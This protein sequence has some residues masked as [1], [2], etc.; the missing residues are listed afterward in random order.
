MEYTDKILNVAQ[1]IVDGMKCLKKNENATGAS[2][3]GAPTDPPL[4]TLDARDTAEEIQ[5]RV[6]AKQEILKKMHN[7]N[8]R[9]A[10]VSARAASR[11]AS[12]AAA[13]RAHSNFLNTLPAPPAPG[14]GAPPPPPPPAPGAGAPPPPPPPAPGAAA[15]GAAAPAPSSLLAPPGARALQPAL[16]RAKPPA[17]ARAHSNFLNTLPAPPAPGAGAPPPPPPAAAKGVAMPVVPLLRD[18][19]GRRIIPT[20][21]LTAAHHKGRVAFPGTRRTVNKRTNTKRRSTYRR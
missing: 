8:E 2:G 20:V 21:R 15:P 9:D 11:A 5:E 1:T 7:A 17:A 16:S 3:A 14:A 10:L 13:A 18:G 6:K 4:K 19:G 12:R